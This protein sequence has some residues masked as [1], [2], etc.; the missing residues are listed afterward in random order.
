MTR[1]TVGQIPDLAGK[2][3]VVTGANSGIGFWTAYWLAAKGAK[4]VI[5]SR[6]QE[7]ADTAIQ[8]MRATQPDLELDM[9]P[10]DLAN[11][12]SVHGFATAFRELDTSLD[13]LVNNAGVMAIP[14]RQTTDDF[15]MQFGTNHLGHFALTGL[16]LQELLATPA[17]RVVTVSSMV[18]H[19]GLMDFDNLNGEKGYDPWTA[20]RQSK[21]ANLLFAYELQHRLQASGKSLISVAVHPGYS[22]T[23]LQFVGPEMDRSTWNRLYWKF[24]N[25]VVAQSAEKGALPSLF[26]AT[27]AEIKGGEFIAPNGMMEMRGYPVKSKSSAASYNLEDAARLWQISE[28]LTGIQFSFSENGKPL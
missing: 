4:V 1:W 26:A 9:I 8:K 16:L 20:Y 17:G 21:L 12:E 25:I 23:N 3:A 22:A 10:L 11:L 2:T 13:I 27:S 14:Y 15:E 19:Q 28:S 6:N 7:K 18:H 5:A 24:L